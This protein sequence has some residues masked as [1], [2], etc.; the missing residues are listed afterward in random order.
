MVLGSSVRCKGWALGEETLEWQAELLSQCPE[1][2][3]QSVLQQAELWSLCPRSL[4]GGYHRSVASTSM[5]SVF[6]N[7]TQIM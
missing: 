5:N 1:E 6:N 2:T 4:H 3:A 7:M